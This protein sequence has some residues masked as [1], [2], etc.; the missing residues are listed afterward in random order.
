MLTEI[1]YNEKGNTNLIMVILLIVTIATIIF[2]LINYKYQSEGNNKSPTF[3]AELFPS[4]QKTIL[5][6]K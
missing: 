4:Y 5:K 1:N 6:R 2:F 3:K